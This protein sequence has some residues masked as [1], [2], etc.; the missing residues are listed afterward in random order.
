LFVAAALF[1][2]VARLRLGLPLGDRDDLAATGVGADSARE[3]RALPANPLPVFLLLPY[4]VDHVAT[5]FGGPCACGEV[6]TYLGGVF[7]RQLCT[8]RDLGLQHSS[9]L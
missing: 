6:G 8:L 7:K 9:A 3:V 5:S 4:D 2:L 1:L